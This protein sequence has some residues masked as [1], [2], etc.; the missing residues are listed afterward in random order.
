VVVELRVALVALLLLI[1]G[2]AAL[3]VWLDRRRRPR[4]GVELAGL[5]EAPLGLVVLEGDGAYGY[6]NREAQRL[7]EL[8][9]AD[10]ALPDERWRS[11]LVEDL[12][13]ARAGGVGPYRLVRV[14]AEGH[15][16]WRVA[17]G[18]DGR[19][20]LFVADGSEGRRLERTAQLFVGALSHELRTPLTAIL[21]HV[22]LL[23]QQAEADPT[24]RSSVEF[25]HRETQRIVRLVSDLLDLSRLSATA[26][27]TLR[28]VDPLIVAEEAVAAVILAADAKDVDVVVEAGAARPRVLADPDR[29]KQVFLNLLDNAVKYGRAGDKVRVRLELLSERVVCAVEDSGPG[30]APEHLPYVRERLYRGRRDVAGTGLGLALVEEILRLHGSALELESAEGQGTAAR[31]ELRVAPIAAAAVGVRS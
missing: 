3:A 13:Q 21:A 20:L 30:I 14:G 24:R 23:A 19:A 26:E 18:Q 29:L 28:P 4:V 16:R 10:G 8:P 31:F 1:V 15:V 11:T 5:D 22:E 2:A 27:L 25:I 12:A 17:A 6:A 7:L 9:A